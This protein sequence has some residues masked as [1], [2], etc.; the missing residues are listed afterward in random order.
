MFAKIRGLVD[1]NILRCL[2]A[3]GISGE[4]Y[5]PALRDDALSM[6]ENIASV[7]AHFGVR[8]VRA[9]RDRHAAWVDMSKESEVLYIPDD[10]LSLLA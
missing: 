5:D 7:T 3:N 9:E 8:T 1:A 10:Y 6:A 4:Y 2:E